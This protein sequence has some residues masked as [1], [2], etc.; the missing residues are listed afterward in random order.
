MVQVICVLQCLNHIGVHFLIQLIVMFREEQA[1]KLEIEPCK[2]EKY[3]GTNWNIYDDNSIRL[4]TNE[5]CVTYNTD[6]NETCK[7]LNHR[8]N[9]LYLSKCKEGLNNQ[10][11][12]VQGRNIVAFDKNS[13]VN[14]D[15][16]IIA[17]IIN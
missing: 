1:I 10:Q 8:D 17:L 2:D 14:E 9:Y 4:G 15:C 13:Q 5:Y 7:S 16:Y 6:K 11:F 3:V 12:L